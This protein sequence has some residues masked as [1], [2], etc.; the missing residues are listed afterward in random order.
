MED[1]WFESQCSQ[2]TEGVLVVGE[3]V[4]PLLSTAGV[5]LSKVPNVHI[6]RCDELAPHSW[7]DLPS[8]I[9]Y[10]ARDPRRDYQVVKKSIQYV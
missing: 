2:N 8:P 3:G 10:P 9:P 7:V 6:G 4:K 5:P 1:S